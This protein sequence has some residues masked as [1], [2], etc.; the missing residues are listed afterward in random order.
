MVEIAERL[1]L[2]IDAKAS[3]AVAELRKAAKSAEELAVTQDRAALASAKMGAA[4]D[5]LAASLAKQAVAEAKAAGDTVALAEAQVTA[6][7]A[8]EKANLSRVGAVVAANKLSVSELAAKDATVA[9]GS[10]AVATG[11]LLDKLGLSALGAGGALASIGPIF[12]LVALAAGVKVLADGVKH[13]EELTGQVRK[14]KSV[15][16][17][18]ATDASLLVGQMKQ[19]GVDPEAA[20]KAF[21]RFGAALG[22]GSSKL[23][24]FGV[25]T[26]HLKDGSTDLVGTFEN[27]RSAYQGSSDA[28]TKDAIAKQLGA[29]AATALIP[30]LKQTKEQVADLNKETR[31][32]GGIM[33]DQDIRNGRDLAVAGRQLSESFANLELSL[34]RGVVPGLAIASESVTKIVNGLH[35]LISKP[36][37]LSPLKH[38]FEDLIHGKSIDDLK[39]LATQ[40]NKE[41]DSKDHRAEVAKEQEAEDKLT[42]SLLGE[43]SAKKAVRD[44]ANSLTDARQVEVDA[45]DTLNKLLRDGAVDEKAVAAAKKDLASASQSLVRAHESERDAVLELNKARERAS[46]LD[47]Q[48]ANNKLALAGDRIG[49]SKAA[50]Q[51]AKEKL[52]ALLGS[53]SATRGQIAEATSELKTRQDEVTRSV[54]DQKRATEDLTKVKQ[55]GSEADPAVVSAERRLRDAHD[56]VKSAIDTQREAL[57]HLHEAEAGDPDFAKKVTEARRDV[58]RAHQAIADAQDNQVTSALRLKSATEQLNAALSGTGGSLFALQAEQGVLDQLLM[59]QSKGL[60]VGPLLAQLPNLLQ[61]STTDPFGNKTG[62]KSTIR[63]AKGGPLEPF[64]AYLV[65]EPGTGGEILQMGDRGGYAR[66]AG[67]GGHTFVTNIKAETGASAAEIARELSW[68]LRTTVLPRI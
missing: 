64:Q 28:A 29:R 23:N 10:G 7:A 8:S 55:K 27:L 36:L 67:R 65:A 11:G 54:I 14:F 24:D 45:Q 3:G 41:N 6:A 48:E 25:A 43:V 44:A 16:G 47:V 22:D 40:Q 63:R 30:L 66:P 42:S 12:A 20:S 53:G 17:A 51:Q 62:T 52:D 38:Q 1:A 39:K 26:A 9:L 57:G 15:T 32:S 21:F 46:V 4:S 2:I 33:S 18:T 37:D 13:F 5:K 61:T 31:A 34:A 49:S 35:Q 56:G 58:A 68:S 60:N 59:L 19:L 50:A